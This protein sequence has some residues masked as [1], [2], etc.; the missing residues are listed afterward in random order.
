MASF[1]FCDFSFCRRECNKVSHVLAK[2][3]ALSELPS[4]AWVELAP[5]F[6][7]DQVAS[8]LAV[9]QV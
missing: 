1:V 4:P 8:D 5:A 9:H 7:L 2:H 3:G 6:V